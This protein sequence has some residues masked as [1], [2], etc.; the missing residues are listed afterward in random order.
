M[1]NAY[2][3]FGASVEDVLRTLNAAVV[4]DLARHI[5]PIRPGSS[6]SVLQ[7]DST[8][9]LAAGM[10]VNINTGSFPPDGE[11][12]VVESI[13]SPTQ[14]TVAEPFSAAPVSGDAL[15]DGP[16]AVEAAMAEAVALIEAHLPD[17]YRRLL[18]RVEGEVIVEAA[19]A[20]QLAAPLML[21][22][23]TNLVL[24]ADYAG[25]YAD[26]GPRDAM[27]PATYS[28]QPNGE[29]VAFSP[30]LSEGTR[31]VADYDTDLADGLAVLAELVALRAAACLARNSLVLEPQ[32]AEA[33]AAEA[34]K[35]LAAL[36]DGACG[37]A[38]LD[39]LRLYDDWLRAAR[40][41]RVGELLR[42]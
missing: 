7:V 35:R 24:Y 12:R 26:R 27:D 36:A 40:G 38:E 17:R 16:A 32:R 3:F 6:A 39:A 33:L 34:D 30:P 29:I 42:S 37:V 41:I 8:A 2:G 21:P 9:G 23:A 5:T 15:N 14:L 19:T 11:T 31:V 10:K 25:P 13:D 28:L 4:S 22:R 18:R 1:S 20:G